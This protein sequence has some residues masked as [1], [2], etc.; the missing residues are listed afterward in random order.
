MKKH[1]KS[2]LNMQGYCFLLPVCWLLCSCTGKITDY[3][4]TGR[5]PVIEPDYS[6]ISIPPNIAP[7]NFA[8]K[9]DGDKFVVNLRTSD[10]G[11]SFSTKSNDNVIR[12][13]AG[14]W[15]QVMAKSL[16]KD[17]IIDVYTR[18]GGRWQRYHPV[19]N[20]VAGDSIDS[21]LA[22][23]L[24]EPG[25][26]MWGTMGIYQRCLENFE[27]SP[28]MINTLSGHNCMNCHS[29]AMNNSNTMLFHMRGKESGTIIF[30]NGKLSKVNTKTDKTISAGVYPAWHP[31][32]RFVAF[33][34]NKIM[35]AFHAVTD[36]RIEVA[37]TLSD[38]VLFD[39]ETSIVSTS[40]ELST[41]ARFETFPTWSPDGKYLYYCSAKA[42]PF[43]QYNKIRYD[44]LKIEFD[45]SSSH[46]G[47]VDTIIS[48][49]KT[50]MSVS[51]PRI[52]PDGKF[53]LFCMSEYGNF[54][55]WHN[56]SDLYMMNLETGE[57]V[58]PEINSPK[59]ESYHTWSSEG[60][61]IVFSSRRD[62]GLFTRPYFSY[63]DGDGV[64][65]KPFILPQKDPG[66]YENFLKAYNV[67]ELITTKIQLNPKII[68][69][70]GD[71]EPMTSA[72]SE[73]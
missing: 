11:L 62:D 56:E 48:S 35:Q 57:I 69:R 30:R 70:L 22:Y 25:F 67:P 27:E 45:Q 55:I 36:R 60:R 40:P 5:L 14:K 51:F 1:L 59:A 26:E 66:F 6:E 10:G 38:I 20:H 12:F 8:V 65:H 47:H 29:F 7:M 16:G 37:D 71:L 31:A 32:G 73:N 41:T 43:K 42:L 23:R 54:T 64:F 49:V 34:V 3:T 18:K 2:L 9:E 72:F 46:F 63:F 24:I 52:S 13:D 53:L 4:E 21:Y 39:T 17:V 28:V 33:S 68:S 61:W 58:K 50:G 19:V 44:L 15:K